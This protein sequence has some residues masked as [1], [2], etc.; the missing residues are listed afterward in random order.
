MMIILVHIIFLSHYQTYMRKLL[1]GEQLY[2][3]DKDLQYAL[4]YALLLIFVV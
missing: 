4:K 1:T 3:I 2:V